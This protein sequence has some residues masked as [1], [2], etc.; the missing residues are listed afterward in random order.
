MVSD[1]NNDLTATDLGGKLTNA[2]MRVEPLANDG[3][4]VFLGMDSPQVPLDEVV[5]GLEFASSSSSSS[6]SNNSNKKQQAPMALLCP[7]DDGGYGM[8]CVPSFAAR[9]PIFKGVRW[10]HP[11]TAVSQLKALTDLE[12]SVKL[13]RLMQDIDEPQDVILLAKRLQLLLTNN[14]YH[15][16][17]EDDVLL[18]PSCRGRS[19]HSKQ[20][21]GNTCENTLLALMRQG[22]V[23]FANDGSMIV[24]AE[25]EQIA[26]TER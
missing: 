10:S 23:T 15:D 5:H 9:L 3:G 11:L 6:S 13:G 22:I 20:Q 8:L 26:K 1:S 21:D 19:N 25:K 24:D 7:A 14:Q 17:D 4:I 16:N 2:L 18:K 12:I